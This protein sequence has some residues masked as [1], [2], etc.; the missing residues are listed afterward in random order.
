[1]EN[2]KKTDALYIAKVVLCAAAIIVCILGLVKIIPASTAVSVSLIILSVIMGV[3][4]SIRDFKRGKKG[5][6]A[7]DVIMGVLLLALSINNI[8][9]FIK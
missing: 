4:E 2:K 3:F 1:M 7:V 8:F 5:W 6:I 9:G